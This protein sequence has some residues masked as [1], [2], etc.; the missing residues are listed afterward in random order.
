MVCIFVSFLVYQ[1]IYCKFWYET[2]LRKRVEQ[3]CFIDDKI[4]Y[5]TTGGSEVSKGTTSIKI[6][7][8]SHK[9][10]SLCSPANVINIEIQVY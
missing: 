1:K 2:K 5:W 10:S 7:W 8:E 4:L 9:L 3:F 6:G